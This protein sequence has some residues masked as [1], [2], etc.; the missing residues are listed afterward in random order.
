MYVSQILDRAGMNDLMDAGQ[1]DAQ[2]AHDF[3]EYVNRRLEF[4]TEHL[5]KKVKGQS[6]HYE[7]WSAENR[8]IIQYANRVAQL[9]Q[10]AIREAKLEYT[11]DEWAQVEPRDRASE[12]RKAA[13]AMVARIGG[14]DPMSVY[15]EAQSLHPGDWYLWTV[16]ACKELDRT[17]S[18]WTMNLSLGGLNGGVYGITDFQACNAAVARKKQ[19]LEEA[20]TPS[21]DDLRRAEQ[22]LVDAGVLADD[23]EDVLREA[24]VRL[25]GRDPYAG[26]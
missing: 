6:H 2:I 17:W 24:A 15:A 5:D 16:A 21:E 1:L 11:E 13:V 19:A 18:V 3:G 14:Y 7:M 8:R 4:Q 9:A 22:A 26:P 12:A 23:V 25:T 20:R 10:A